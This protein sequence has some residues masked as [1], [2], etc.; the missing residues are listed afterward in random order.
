MHI[1]DTNTSHF[2]TTASA[3]KKRKRDVVAGPWTQEDNN[4]QG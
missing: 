3:L 4:L 2:D 1:P